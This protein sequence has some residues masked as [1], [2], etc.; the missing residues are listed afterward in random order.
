MLHVIVL[1]GSLKRH[2]VT[3]VLKITRYKAR[4]GGAAPRGGVEVG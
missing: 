1:V 4:H 2:S 3:S